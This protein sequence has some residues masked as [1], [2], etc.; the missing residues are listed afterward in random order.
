MPHQSA[1]VVGRPRK[2]TVEPN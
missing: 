2:P 1:R